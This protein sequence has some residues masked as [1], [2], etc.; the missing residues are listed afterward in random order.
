MLE[1]IYQIIQDRRNNPKEDSYTSYLHR[2]GIDK[3]LKKLG[4]ESS[5]VIIAAKNADAQ[6]MVEELA[7]LHFHLLVLMEARGLRLE[8]VNAELE[9]RHRG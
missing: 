5:E 7:D 8:Q 4:E 6:R 1:K 9:K 2:E 3:I